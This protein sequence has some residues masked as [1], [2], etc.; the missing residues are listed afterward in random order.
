MPKGCSKTEDRKEKLKTFIN[1]SC[2]NTLFYKKE[3]NFCNLAKN[4]VLKIPISE[5][6]R[7]VNLAPNN[8]RFQHPRRHET[9][10]IV[11]ATLKAR[12]KTCSVK[13]NL[14]N[15]IKIL[16]GLELL[17]TYRACNGKQ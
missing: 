7:K 15:N 3:Y 13:I 14:C 17:H 6:Y 4:G 16:S 8:W 10:M 9:A 5:I 1:F 2:C 11:K 12:R